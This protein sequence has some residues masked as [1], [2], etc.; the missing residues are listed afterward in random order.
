MKRNRADMN[1][2]RTYTNRPNKFARRWTPPRMLAGPRM[3]NGNY[4][5]GGGGR[6]ALIVPGYTRTGGAYGR[7]GHGNLPEVKFFDTIMGFQV[8]STGEVPATGQLSLIPQGDT[9][10]TRDGR[11]ATI[12]SVQVNAALTWRPGTVAEPTGCTKISLILDKQCNGSAASSAEMFTNDNVAFG[13]INLDNNDRFT[14]IKQWTHNWNSMGINA[15]TSVH[16]PQCKWI[17]WYKKTDIPMS[18]SGAT[19][20]ITEIKS[21]NLFLYAGATS[22]L[23]IDDQVSCSGTVRLRFKG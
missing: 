5:S 19:G 23:T 7:T 6:V 13:M 20:A 1:V 17:R 12:T 8:D 2:G 3:R 4:I 21:N 10:T 18:W 22:N 16:N 14:I 15:T 11:Q 9:S